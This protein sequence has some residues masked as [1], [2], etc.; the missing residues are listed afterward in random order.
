MTKK[1]IILLCLICGLCGAKA[2][3]GTVN[4][5]LEKLE[6]RKNINRE[7]RKESLDGKKFVTIKEFNDHTERYFLTVTGNK[8]NF[9][10]VFDDKASGKSSSNVFSGDVIRTKNNALSFRFDLL[11]GKKIALPI[12]KTMLLTKQKEVLYLVD[13]NTKDRWIDEGSL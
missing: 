8:A 9:I 4:A 7:V 11:E 2:Q 13:V 1:T 3:Y 12:T 5:I 6:A 10:E